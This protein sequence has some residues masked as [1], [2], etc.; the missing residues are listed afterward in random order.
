VAV[1]RI[2]ASKLSGRVLPKRQGKTCFN[3]LEDGIGPRPK[4]RSLF[5]LGA[6]DKPSV[7]PAE[8]R[9]SLSS[10]TVLFSWNFSTSTFDSRCVE[11]R[12]GGFRLGAEVMHSLSALPGINARGRIWRPQRPLG[13]FD[14]RNWG[15]FAPYTPWRRRRGQKVHPPRVLWLQHGVGDCS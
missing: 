9:S 11:L 7:L 3:S 10:S 6:K 2:R 14:L 5:R 13:S 4:T 8:G 15:V 1:C 12:H